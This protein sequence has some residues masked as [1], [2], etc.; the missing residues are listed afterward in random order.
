MGLLDFFKPV[1]VWPV[2]RIKEFI[3]D[4]DPGDYNLIDVRQPREYA[5]GHIPGAR[6]MP[7]SQLE[8]FYREFDPDKPTIV[9]CNSGP[10]SQAAASVLSRR[11][12]RQVFC[13]EGG[14]SAW[15]GMVAKGMP[16]TTMVWF[17]PAHTAAQFVALAWLLEKGTREFYGHVSERLTDPEAREL[18]LKLTEAEDHHLNALQK[19]YE[20]FT[21]HAA[22]EEFPFGVID[23]DPGEEPIMEGG[24][25][26]RKAL[27]W[28][29]G[30]TLKEVLELTIGVETVAYDRYLFMLEKIEDEGI[31]KVLKSLALVE[32]KH[33]ETVSQWLEGLVEQKQKISETAIS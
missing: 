8:D 20:K 4:R 3:Q 26:V 11:G 29:H 14:I 6:S 1:A 18:Y 12:F 25:S 10:R 16:E 28:I 13:M 31:R 15:H 21:G 27:G 23:I 32:K 19:I 5:L 30:K 7:V 2:D 33:L 24:I 9:Y 22:G 17:F